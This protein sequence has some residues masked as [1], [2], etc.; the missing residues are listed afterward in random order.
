MPSRAERTRR[1][2]LRA[3]AQRFAASGS[4]G[5][6][7]VEEIAAA[8]GVSKGIVYHHFGAKER[9]LEALLEE[10]LAEWSGA[11]DVEAHRA[12]SGSVLAA[13]ERSLRASLDYARHNPLVPVLFHKQALAG[14]GLD[15]SAAMRR[16]QS[17]GRA[18]A[19]AAM[20]AGVEAGELRR[21]LDPERAADL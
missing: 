16:S 2:I 20:R 6:T 18:C 9:I 14:L 11:S 12:R 17:E 8:A 1:R 13:I 15:E 7:T 3:A 4:L 21:D 5:R 10:T 19:L